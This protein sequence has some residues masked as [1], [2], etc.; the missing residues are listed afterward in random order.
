M[1][2]LQK[3][4]FLWGF[5]LF[6]VFNLAV[7]YLGGEYLHSQIHKHESRAAHQQCPIYQLQ[8]QVFTAIGAVLAVLF[9]AIVFTNIVRRTQDFV[10]QLNYILPESH[11][12]PFPL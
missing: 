1:R 4:K 11:A 3:N 10:L 8:T 7:L 6:T 5:L 12:P 2:Q 9:S